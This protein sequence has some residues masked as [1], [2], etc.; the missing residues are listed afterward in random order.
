MSRNEKEIEDWLMD[1]VDIPSGPESEDGEEGD[2]EGASE[3]VGNFTVDESGE[4]LPNIDYLDI[5]QEIDIVDELPVLLVEVITSTISQQFQ[6]FLDT[7]DEILE[8]N[9]HVQV[10]SEEPIDVPGAV[11]SDTNN[12]DLEPCVHE[13]NDYTRLY[14][15]GIAW[16]K[17][18]LK[19]NKKFNFSENIS[20]KIVTETPID[21][22]NTLFSDELVELLV[23]QTDIYMQQK[24]LLD[25]LDFLQTI[26]R[27]GY[28]RDLIYV[29]E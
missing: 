10:I 6:Q 18:Y 20:P 25:Q 13:P 12:V 11:N 26:K 23:V 28:F 8:E 5:V 7:S 22:F 21:S 16:Y 3:V 14:K 27:C 15:N 9:D 2:E 24:K 1:A 17:K 29:W 4:L 19:H